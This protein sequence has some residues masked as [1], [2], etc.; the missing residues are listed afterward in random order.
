MTSSLIKK[1]KQTFCIPNQK[2]KFKHYKASVRKRLTFS[3]KKNAEKLRNNELSETEREELQR[4]G[5]QFKKELQKNKTLKKFSDSYL[6]KRCMKTYCNPGCSGTI[7][8]RGKKMEKYIDIIDH[9][10]I[11]GS[12]SDVLRSDDFYEKMTEKYIQTKKKK[13]AIS[14]CNQDYYPDEESHAWL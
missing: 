5:K 9:K 13:G 1:C 10:D 2:I 6:M 3:I 12:K 14:G 4:K 11:F 8:E 7:F